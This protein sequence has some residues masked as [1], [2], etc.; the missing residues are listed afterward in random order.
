MSVPLFNTGTDRPTRSEGQCLAVYRS[1]QK[2]DVI[3]LDRDGVIGDGHYGKNPER[4]VMLSSTRAYA[5]AETN[6]IALMPGALEENIL[7]D[8]DPYGLPIGTRIEIGEAVLRIAQYGTI[9]KSLTRIDSKLPKLL[10]E[11]R[12]IFAQVVRA[13]R[14]RAGDPIRIVSQQ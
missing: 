11:K 2:R 3:I 7:V 12:G 1:G 5:L 10:K 6:G 14:V 8:I 13:G 4:A 9:C